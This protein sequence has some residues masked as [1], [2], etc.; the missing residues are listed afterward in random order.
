MT[1]SDKNKDAPRLAGVIGSP[2][3]HSL[4]PLIHRT[5]AERENASSF[6]IPIHVEDNFDA[7]KGAADS[8]KK[9]GFKGVNVTLPHKEN[10]LHYA[11]EKTALAQSVGA[12]NMLT[13]TKEGAIADN[14]DVQGFT[15]GLNDL[16]DGKYNKNSALII[17]AGGAARGVAI[18]LKQLGFQSIAITNRTD[19]KAEVVAALAGSCATTMPWNAKD[20]A[21]SEYDLIVN[22]SSLGM[23]DFPSLILPL[24]DA[25][26]SAIICD[27]VYTPLKTELL[28]A[29]ERHGLKTIDGL[30]ML[31][32]Q[33]VPGY[34][35]WLGDE[36]R[37]D[38]DLRHR[39]ETVLKARVTS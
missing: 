35:K 37:V 23:R 38:A 20:S 13:F 16:G 36:A 31:M 5:W 34:Q 39:L 12:A 11:Q 19:Q 32:H 7:F 14:S 10:A 26:K 28:L 4:S 3:S 21:I 27:I 15:D 8:L 18:A 30:S 1:V 33:A 2:I 25:K 29:A 24:A 17:G 6:Y 22:T 9:L